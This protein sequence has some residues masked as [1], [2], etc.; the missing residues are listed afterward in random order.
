MRFPHFDFYPGDW[1]NDTNNGLL[2]FE[3]R[4]VHIELLCLMWDQPD[5]T[6]PDDDGVIARLLHVSVRQWK[7][8]RQ[9]LLDGDHPVFVKENG[10]FFSK[11]LLKMWHKALDK[12]AKAQ[13]AATERW[14]AK[15]APEAGS[16]KTTDMPSPSDSNAD[17]LQMQSDGNASH[18]SSVTDHKSLKTLVP[19]N[20]PE[21]TDPKTLRPAPKRTRHPVTAEIRALTDTLATRLFQGEPLPTNWRSKNVQCLA[22]LVDRWGLDNVRAC[23]NWMWQDPYWRTQFDSWMALE[24]AYPKWRASQQSQNTGPPPE[25]PLNFVNLE[26]DPVMQQLR[27]VDAHAPTTRTASPGSRLHCSA[28]SVAHGPYLGARA[29]GMVSERDRATGLGL[30]DSPT[31]GATTG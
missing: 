5:C 10:R 26:T 2:T 12:S 18:Q 19:G 27:E 16:E 14:N 4:G 7:K 1:R 30:G 6:L 29:A 3:E 15:P 20:A 23:A 17:A 28:L 13:A 11:K 9:H 8:W 22:K 25:R 31:P 21:P 24:R